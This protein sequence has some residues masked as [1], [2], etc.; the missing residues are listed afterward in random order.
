MVYTCCVSGCK[1]GCKSQKNSKKHTLF[2]FPIDKK[3]KQNWI[4]AISRKN[5]V[6]NKNHKVCSKYF[7]SDEY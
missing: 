6:I 5:W 1:T 7:L 2:R 3:L 4:A